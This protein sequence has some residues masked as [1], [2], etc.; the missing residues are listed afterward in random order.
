MAD[1][2]YIF[3]EIDPKLTAEECMKRFRAVTITQSNRGIVDRWIK[4]FN[5]YYGF[6]YSDP[7]TA[8]GIGESGSQGEFTAVSINHYRNL[9]QHIL[10]L[11][12]QNK[13]AFDAIPLNSDTEGRNASIV[14]NAVLEYYFEQEKYSQHLYQLAEVGLLYGTS[15]LFTLWDT[16]SSFHS[17]DGDGQPVYAGELATQVFSPFDIILEPFKSDF[18]K[19][20]W[21]CTREFCNRFELI[22]QYPDQEDDIL[23]LS[24]I[25]DI[26]LFDPYYTLDSNHVWKYTFYHKATRTLP[27]GRYVV[28]SSETCIYEDSHNPYCDIDPRTQVPIVGTGVPGVCFRPGVNYGSAWGHTV[29]FDMLPLQ[30]LKNLVNSIIATNQSVFGVQNLITPRTS[31]IK[32]DDIATGLRMI[33]FDPDPTLPNGGAPTVL[34]LLKTPV[35]IF[36]YNNKL[37][38][39]LEKISGI[40]G[41]MR[42]TPPPQV[43]SGTAMAL[44]TT[45]VQTFN[46]QLENAYTNSVQSIANLVIK[47]IAKFMMGQDLVDLVGLKENFAIKDF[48]AENLSRIHKIKILTGNA[49]SKSPAGRLAMA[50]DLMQTQQITPQEYTEIIETG[51]IKDKFEDI[52]ASVALIQWENQEML[53]GTEIQVSMLENHLAHIKE[54]I[55]ATLT[56]ELKNDPQKMQIFVKHILDHQQQWVVLGKQNPQLLALITGSPI[57][58][59]VAN[60][61]TM[62]GAQP[63]PGAPG[64]PPPQGGQPPPQ[65][66]APMKAP[67]QAGQIAIPPGQKVAPG[68]V[69]KNNV[70]NASSV[71]GQTD[72]ALSG[73]RA[74]EKLLEQGRK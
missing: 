32:Y 13:I 20:D 6:Y 16:N 7:K 11:L 73:L 39:E 57:P 28:F 44:L 49:M 60:P 69:G 37:D 74:A 4:S 70:T 63:P 50:Q 31:N 41:A 29:G 9:L 53:Q 26:Q 72:V 67:G 19:Q 33:D 45:Q 21:V 17:I 71:N 47:T 14:G 18:T 42:G 68:G 58:P 61:G 35:E 10:A 2:S 8:F 38:E 65:G 55:T 52:T 1:K 43:S 51:Y 30:D 3:S 23:S 48:Q 56:P 46:T 62:P 22:K 59:D 24:N 36:N 27:F 12:T 5:A 66:G 40:N 15:F 64:S 34:E 54:H 25:S